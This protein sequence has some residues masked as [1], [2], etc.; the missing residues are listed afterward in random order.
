MIK[1]STIFAAGL[2]AMGLAAPVVAQ[3]HE[4]ILV[5][6]Q[7]WSF[8]G[9]FG[10]YDEHQLQ[11]GF[12]VFQAVC[13]NCHG[14]RLLAF[15][16][17]EEEGGPGFSEEQVKALA[18]EYTV[19]DPDAEGGTRKGLPSD[20]WP[21]TGQTDADQIAAFG[22]V[23]PDLS[24][25]A[26]ARA[27][28]SPFPQWIFNYFT[29]YSEGGADYMHALLTGYE[30]TPPHGAE[31]PEGKFYNHVFPGHAIG[32]PPPLADGS[33][34]YDTGVADDPNTADKDES[35]RDATLAEASTDV[36]AFLMW[37]A[38]PHLNDQKAAGF[39]VLTFLLLFAVLMWFVKNRIWRNVE[40]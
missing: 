31:V 27:I 32:M 12:Q 15:R 25:M 17:L 9:I 26:K 24:V 23:P 35:K 33:V 16:N 5:E 7:P 34:K 39:R 28:A 40:H 21:G 3:E 8:G 30:E 22:L 1:I 19:N 18:A 4:T 10:K 37:V 14:A 6:R 20:R 38:E 2:I 29:T 36:S 11:R 13:A